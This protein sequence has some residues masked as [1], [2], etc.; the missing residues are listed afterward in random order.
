[1]LP[2]EGEASDAITMTVTACPM[3]DGS[4]SISWKV[5]TS[6]L[7]APIMRSCRLAMSSSCRRAQPAHGATV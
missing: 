3:A 2:I 6:P 4:A 5:F 7:I 1:M